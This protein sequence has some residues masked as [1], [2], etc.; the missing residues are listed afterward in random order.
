[1]ECTFWGNLLFTDMHL[2]WNFYYGGRWS[3]LTGGMFLQYRGTDLVC[4]DSCL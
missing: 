2:R 4:D 1:M 3:R